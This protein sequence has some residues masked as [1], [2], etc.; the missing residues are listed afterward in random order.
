ME[1]EHYCERYLGQWDR[2]A[3]VRKSDH[4]RLPENIFDYDFFP[5]TN[6]PFLNHPSISSLGGDKRREI[7]IRFACRFQSEAADMEQIIINN[8]CE[9]VANGE[10]GIELP[11]SAKQAA[12]TILTDEF[13]HI[14]CEKEFIGDIIKFTGLNIMHPDTSDGGIPHSLKFLRT[15]APPDLMPIAEV[16]GLCFYEN[17]VTEELVG[18]SS[19]T[20]ADNPF[21]LTVREHLED[22]GRH[23][24]YF[25]K[26]LTYIWS[27]L[28]PESQQSLGSI[29]PEFLDIFLLNTKSRIASSKDVLTQS[30]ISEE[31]IE[32]IFNDM[33]QKNYS[34]MPKKNELVSARKPLNLLKRVGFTNHNPTKNLLIQNGWLA[35]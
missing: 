27:S 24:G 15:A 32:A 31:V 1:F 21:H 13:Y 18:I 17:F 14:F 3:K 30:G 28:D 34:L 19:E 25:E 26:L 4:Y 5:K 6:L 16:I 35:S 10:I 2:R 22:E 12:L 20:E 7:M 33:V 23:G 11:L 29:M 8:I 9:K